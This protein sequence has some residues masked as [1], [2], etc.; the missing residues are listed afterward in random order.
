MCVLVGVCVLVD[1]CVLVGVCVCMHMCVVSKQNKVTFLR[2][3]SD[4]NFVVS[5]E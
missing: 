1:V 4:Y 5:Y 2:V 3:G